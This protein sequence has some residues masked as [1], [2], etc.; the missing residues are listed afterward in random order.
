MGCGPQEASQHT[1][2]FSQIQQIHKST[3]GPQEASQHTNLF[4]QIQKIHKFT[5]THKY[6]KYTN[7]H[8]VHKRPHNI[9]IFSHKYKKYTNSHIHTN[10]T[11][12]QIHMRSTRGLLWTACG[13]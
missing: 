1:N 10:I 4:S 13:F 12:T 2:L 8:A 9:Q 3:C 11:N 7:P 5:Y 6:N